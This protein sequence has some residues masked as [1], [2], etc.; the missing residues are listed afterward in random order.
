MLHKRRLP[1]RQEARQLVAPTSA[2]SAHKAA[3]NWQPLGRQ[4]SCLDQPAA[5]WQMGGPRAPQLGGG[6]VA[7]FARQ[8]S[9]EREKAWLH[10][11]DNI[12]NIEYLNGAVFESN[13]RG[14]F[15]ARKLE[16]NEVAPKRDPQ[17]QLGR[18]RGK[19]TQ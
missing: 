14:A 1:I 4:T 8:A 5:G 9:V 10:N 16:L 2:Q 13:R 7:V 12:F 15:H 17:S 3:T 19:A 18:L 11:I 6:Q